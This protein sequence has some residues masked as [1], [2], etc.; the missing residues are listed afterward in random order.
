MKDSFER[1]FN[2]TLKQEVEPG[3]ESDGSLHT[4]PA[5]PGGTTRFGV[6]QR[7]YPEVDLNTLDLAGAKVIYEAI[8]KRMGCDDLPTPLD[9]VVFD[10]AFN[11][12]DGAARKLLR[13]CGGSAEV[14][15]W[16]RTKLYWYLEA[17]KHRAA[18]P[19]WMHRM[20]NLYRE[21][22]PNWVKS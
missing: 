3:H 13:V 16:L 17:K 9:V 19:S 15:M 14:Y 18:F 11:M 21:I 5:D 20:I 7:A 1:A 4:D 12:G 22:K 10:T 8:W 2:F 6:S